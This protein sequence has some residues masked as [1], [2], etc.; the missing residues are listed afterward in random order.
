MTVKLYDIFV[1]II[2]QHTCTKITIVWH[3]KDTINITS[4]PNTKK[5]CLAWDSVKRL[6]EWKN[7]ILITMEKFDDCHTNTRHHV[8]CTEAG[9]LRT[10]E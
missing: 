4:Q 8:S 2:C 7:R 10:V 5:T 1:E 6:N 9:L 3:R